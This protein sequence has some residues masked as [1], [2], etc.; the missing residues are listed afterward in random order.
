MH[1]M[2]AVVDCALVLVPVAVARPRSGTLAADAAE[3]LGD[4]GLENGLNQLADFFAADRFEGHQE[5]FMR[6]LWQQPA[7]WGKLSSRRISGWCR[8]PGA[9]LL[10]FPSPP[11][12]G[13][14]SRGGLLGDKSESHRSGGGLLVRVRAGAFFEPLWSEL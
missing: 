5:I 4:F 8:N 1:R 2:T 11:E 13:P 6:R 9:T 3:K 10:Y 7:T 12:I 14:A